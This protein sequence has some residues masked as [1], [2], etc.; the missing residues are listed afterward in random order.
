MLNQLTRDLAADPALRDADTLA[1][2]IMTKVDEAEKILGKAPAIE[3]DEVVKDFSHVIYDKNGVALTQKVMRVPNTLGSAKELA[4][5][6]LNMDEAAL[7]EGR[8]LFGQNP[9]SHRAIR[10]RQV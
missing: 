5:K 6:L 3:V 10:S 8:T 9:R 1:Q 2:H 7:A 4:S